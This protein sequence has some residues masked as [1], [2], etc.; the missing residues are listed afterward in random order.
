MLLGIYRTGL[1]LLVSGKDTR[2]M[3][4]HVPLCP[5]G[6]GKYSLEGIDPIF[7]GRHNRN[8]VACRIYERVRDMEEEGKEK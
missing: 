3:S 1:G 2:A 8:E 6:E 5:E 4:F 7:P